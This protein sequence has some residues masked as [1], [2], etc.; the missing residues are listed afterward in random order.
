[1]V[2][3]YAIVVV[4]TLLAGAWSIPV[5]LLLGLPPGGARQRR[6]IVWDPDREWLWVAAHGHDHRTTHKIVAII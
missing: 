4:V 6:G 2:L 3:E 1:M 5:G